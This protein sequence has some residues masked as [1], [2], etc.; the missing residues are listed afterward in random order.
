LEENTVLVPSTPLAIQSALAFWNLQ[1]LATMEMSAW[2]QERERRARTVK[3]ERIVNM[4]FGRK[5]DE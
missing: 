3:R 1:W 5:S 4:S 2:T